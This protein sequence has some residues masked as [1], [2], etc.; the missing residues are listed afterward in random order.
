MEHDQESEAFRY[1]AN[2]DEDLE[3]LITQHGQPPRLRR[4]ASFGTLVHIILEQQ[5]SLASAQASFNKLSKALDP[6]EPNAFLHVSQQDLKGYGFSRQ[7]IRYCRALA[8][9]LIDKR[10]HLPTLPSLSDEDVHAELCKVVGIGDWTGQIYLMMV[11][12]RPDIFPA[13]DLALQ[14]AVQ[15]LK[16]LKSR[17]NAKDLE[18]IATTWKP[19]RSAA[20]RLL[21]HYYLL[22]R[23]NKQR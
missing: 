11:L 10:L 17:P 16:G 23:A 6:L 5:V 19:F 2:V 8:A 4:E 18:T 15:K 21:W 13:K 20:A 14:I 12:E 9:A 7:K 3:H 1:L 22:G